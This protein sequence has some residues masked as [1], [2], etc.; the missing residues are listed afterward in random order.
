MPSKKSWQLCPQI[1]FVR[2]RFDVYK[3][4]YKKSRRIFHRFIDVLKLLLLDEAY[5]DVTSD[6]QDIRSA[7][8]IAQQ[9]KKLCTTSWT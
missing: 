8:E 3:A 9:I 5:P 4:M 6:K 2:P 1:I 7:I